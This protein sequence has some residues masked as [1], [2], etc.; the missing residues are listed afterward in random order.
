MT[1]DAPNIEG[2]GDTSISSRW[3]RRAGAFVARTYGDSLRDN[4]DHLE[5]RDGLDA[6]QAAIFKQIKADY[7]AEMLK[8]LPDFPTMLRIE[9][10]LVDF[11]SDA[12]ILQR[13]W[14]VEDRFERI[15]PAGTRA[16][17]K[18]S[19]PQRGDKQWTDAAYVRRQI[20]SLLDSIHA[21]YT[22]NLARERIVQGLKVG[23]L[24]V[25]SVAAIIESILGILYAN[26][27]GIAPL[28]FGLYTLVVVGILGAALSMSRRLQVA[29]SHD[30]MASDGIFEL[31]GLRLGWV[32]MVLSLVMGGAFALV[33]YFI[34]Q[35]GVLSVGYPS[36]LDRP[37]GAVA[38]GDTSASTSSEAASATSPENSSQREPPNAMPAAVKTPACVI[39][40]CP[41]DADTGLIAGLAPDV[42][43]NF[44]SASS[45]VPLDTGGHAC[46]IPLTQKEAQL[47]QAMRLRSMTDF[48]KMLLLAFLAGFAEQFVPDIL[49]RLTKRQT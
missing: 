45:G 1:Q 39:E 8:P 18:A 25:I 19:L 21:N 46:K 38:E 7:E 10:A 29:V 48:Y 36:T 43:S 41:C 12:Y 24:G 37:V 42:Q 11:A 17:F 2:V 16:T 40:P 44:A 31:I 30:A 14:A 49:N 6:V 35:S 28:T 26:G 9:A 27:W 33:V 4:F 13:Y 15:L 3:A 22:V 47:L 20:R 32:G 5:V 34:A 23:M